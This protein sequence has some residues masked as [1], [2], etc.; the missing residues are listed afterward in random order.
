MQLGN[1][2]YE[3]TPIPHILSTLPRYRITVCISIN[4]Q[5]ARLPDP[6]K[7]KGVPMT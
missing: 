3:L 7:R 6:L 4:D 5:L 2:N 1:P